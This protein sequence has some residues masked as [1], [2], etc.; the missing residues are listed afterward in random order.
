MPN[1][2]IRTESEKTMVLRGKL[3]MAEGQQQLARRRI[4]CTRKESIRVG[5][6][7]ASR[8]YQM[9]DLRLDGGRIL[10]NVSHRSAFISGTRLVKQGDTFSA[11]KTGA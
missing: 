10:V 9:T 1:S 8:G 2:I 3:P 4:E 7:A 6:S 5:G 11:V